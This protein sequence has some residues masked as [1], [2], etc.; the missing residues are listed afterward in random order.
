MSKAVNGVPP[1][2]M[3]CNC[4][5]LL[6]LELVVPFLSFPYTN[7]VVFANKLIIH[8]LWRNQDRK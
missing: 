4:L 5:Y 6:L 2:V 3:K 8:I 7:F 1:F